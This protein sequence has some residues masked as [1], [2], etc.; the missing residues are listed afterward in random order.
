MHVHTYPGRQALKIYPD[1]V[2]IHIHIYKHIHTYM[3]IL[4][5]DDKLFRFTRM[6][7]EITTMSRLGDAEAD[8][9]RLTVDASLQVNVVSLGLWLS[10]HKQIS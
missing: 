1:I 7:S 4:T 5:L 8:G 9:G 6:S 10:K 2:H 3:Y